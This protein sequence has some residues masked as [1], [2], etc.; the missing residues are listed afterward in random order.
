[1]IYSDAL[2]IVIF[3]ILL[4]HDIDVNIQDK[5]GKTALHA[6]LS[7]QHRPPS[8]EQKQLAEKLLKTTD[9]KLTDQ[10]GYDQYLF[11]FKRLIKL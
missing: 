3:Q 6:C 10:N 7:N 4:A 9:L 5:W 8:D 11:G 2:C 1:M